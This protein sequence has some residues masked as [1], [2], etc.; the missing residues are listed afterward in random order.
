MAEQMAEPG[1]PQLLRA[2]DPLP[3]WPGLALCDGCHMALRAAGAATPLYLDGVFDT[4][5][6]MLAQGVQ[7]PFVGTRWKCVEVPG[8]PGI[9]RL[10]CQ[11]DDEYCLAADAP[12]LKLEVGN[13]DHVLRPMQWLLYRLHDRMLI[14]SKGGDWL[15]CKRGKPICGPVD[16]LTDPTY[17]W[18]PERYW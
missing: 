12:A 17:H 14:R 4:R 8:Q 1:Q 13:P 15:G 10:V 18:I 16:D 11:N 2:P 7:A 9:W 6:I 5:R 3:D